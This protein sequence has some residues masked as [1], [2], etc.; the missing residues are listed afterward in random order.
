MKRK[1]I[2]LTLC[3]LFICASTPTNAYGRSAKQLRRQ[4]IA[5][6]NEITFKKLR[7][8]TYKVRY[9]LEIARRKRAENKPTGSSWS[10]WDYFVITK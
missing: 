7:P 4:K 6:R 1:A 3:M 10:F 5:R 8:G 2:I 9:R